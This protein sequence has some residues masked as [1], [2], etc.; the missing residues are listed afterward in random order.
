MR[1]GMIVNRMEALDRVSQGTTMESNE[2]FIAKVVGQDL[3]DFIFSYR[4]SK[5]YFYWSCWADPE[6]MQIDLEGL[7]D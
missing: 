7:S 3:G 4:S 1:P 2:V 5:M 6:G